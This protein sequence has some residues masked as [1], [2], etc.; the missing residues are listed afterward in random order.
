MTRALSHISRSLEYSSCRTVSSSWLVA[1]M[2]DVEDETLQQT[3]S[4]DPMNPYGDD[5]QA[6]PPEQAGNPTQEDEQ[7]EDDDDEPPRRSRYEDD[8][9]EEEEEEEEDDAG[10]ERGKKKVKVCSFYLCLVP[11]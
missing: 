10:A 3:G 8:E 1:V 4:D 9:D 7:E 11:V 6:E 5:D 2:S